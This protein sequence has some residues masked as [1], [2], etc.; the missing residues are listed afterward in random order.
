MTPPSSRWRVGAPLLTSVTS[1]GVVWS[2]FMPRVTAQILASN[3]APQEETVEGPNMRWY[4]IF[5]I[6][7]FVLFLFRVIITALHMGTARKCD[8]REQSCDHLLQVSSRG[9]SA[10]STSCKISRT[11]LW[12][13]PCRAKEVAKFFFQ[14]VTRD[15]S[16]I[17]HCDYWKKEARSGHSDPM[18]LMVTGE[19]Q[20]KDNVS[21]PQSLLSTSLDQMGPSQGLP[22]ISVPCVWVLP[23]L[24][25]DCGPSSLQQGSYSP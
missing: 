10:G 25:A 23:S 9:D 1:H 2:R 16:G 4:L 24:C 21:Q 12:S 7:V 14:N 17:Y 11:E 22:S 6:W 19:W 13:N 8:F 15:K 20:V 18:S 3:P 5:D